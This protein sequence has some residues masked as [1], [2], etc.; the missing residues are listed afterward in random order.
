[1]PSRPMLPA[2]TASRPAFVT[3]AIRPLQWDE[4]ARSIAVIRTSENQNIFPMGWTT[5]ITPAGPQAG[6]R[7]SGDP[8]DGTLGC[9]PTAAGVEAANGMTSR[10]KTCYADTKGMS[11][12]AIAGDAA[13]SNAPGDVASAHDG[14]RSI[15]GNACS[16]TS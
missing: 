6:R 14:R 3:I 7:R 10:D 11:P 15:H 9:R 1:M 13:F 2:S 16:T 4:T 8:P 12:E 5:Q